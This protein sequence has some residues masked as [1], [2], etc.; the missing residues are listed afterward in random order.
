VTGIHVRCRDVALRDRVQR[1]IADGRV[2][3]PADV[4]VTLDLIDAPWAGLETRPAFTQ[5][6]LRFHHGPPD[7][8]VRVVWRDGDGH[9]L[10]G[11]A[12]ARTATIELVRPIATEPDRW[13]R[14]FLLPALLVLLRRAG[15][16]HIHAATARDPR[17][18]GWLIA[19]DARAGKSTTAA[20]LAARGWAVGSDDT[21]F[22]VTGNDRVSARSWC[23]PI[24]LRD[25]GQ[26]LL[27]RAGGR[28]LP[29]RGKTAFTPEQ[30]GGTWLGET[31]VDIVALASVHDGPTRLTPV[32][33][34]V[35]VAELLSWSMLF[36]VDPAEAQAHL[37]LIARLARQAQCVRLALGRDL[38]ERAVPLETLVP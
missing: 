16:H 15:C 35:A 24:A 29:R 19:G 25:G 36:V 10:L 3:P 17:G 11:P 26:E 32:A 20:V 7:H 28:A 8:S 38:V 6:G 12:P 34:P 31:P 13:L 14:A 1:W 5:P 30:L 4:E 33:R 21:A 27:A 2:I 23:E 9:A 18:R 22:L 37:D